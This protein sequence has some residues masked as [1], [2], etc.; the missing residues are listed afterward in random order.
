MRLVPDHGDRFRA[1]HGDGA[2]RLGE[3]G[4]RFQV[5]RVLDLE[6]RPYGVAQDFGRLAGA[7]ERARE[8]PLGAHLE[9]LQ[10][11]GGEAELVNSLWGKRAVVVPGIGGVAAL[12]GDGVTHDVEIH[13]PLGEKP[14]ITRLV[15]RLAIS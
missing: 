2:K 4:V 9:L 12:D 3:V 13:S 6:V 15:A 7:N 14:G 11:P 10:A 1:E 8:D 5:W